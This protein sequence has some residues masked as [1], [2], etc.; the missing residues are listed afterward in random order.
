MVCAAFC[1]EAFVKRVGRCWDG[2]GAIFL[3][4]MTHEDGALFAWKR[5]GAFLD[6]VD[7]GAASRK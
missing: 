6:R 2:F 1:V 4:C 3:V 7:G 5:Y